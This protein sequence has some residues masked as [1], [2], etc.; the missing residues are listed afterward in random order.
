MSDEIAL[1][2][3]KEDG[4]VEQQRL[5]IS[6]TQLDVLFFSFSFVVASRG[7]CFPQLFSRYLVAVS[8]NIAQ[9]TRVAKLRVGLRLACV[10]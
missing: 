2:L 7:A 1:D 3:T 9:L 6:T 5:P 8:G 4:S 10:A